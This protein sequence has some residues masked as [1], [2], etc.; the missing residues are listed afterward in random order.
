MSQNRL[1]IKVGLFVCICLGVLAGLLLEFSK[2][3]T[4]FRDTYS[5]TLYA[6]NVGGLKPRSQVLMS[7]V[8]VGTV[9]RTELDQSGTNVAIYL[10]IYS[11]YPI[12]SDA[13]FIIEQFGF[14]GDQYVA[15][16]PQSGSAEK[17]TS[18]AVVQ[19]DA[20]FNLQEVARSTS[21]FI[22]RLD[23]SARKVDAAIDEVRRVLLN[24]K[25]LSNLTDT[26]VNA[27][28]ASANA[29]TAVDNLNNLIQANSG[30]AG[31]AI[32]NLVTFS[33]Q[34]ED[35]ST[36][37]QALLST[38]GPTITAAI[39]NIQTSTAQITNLLTD[40]NSG[41]GLAGALLKDQALSS[42]VSAAMSNIAITTS[43]LNRMGFW[44]WLWYKPGEKSSSEG[45]VY[46]KSKP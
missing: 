1:E 43:N 31:T 9:A 12:R 37:A 6:P 40:L 27:R 29:V 18:G 15:I 17:L 13:R 46:P 24:D 35:F 39:S 3:V 20:P 32:T 23:V 8:Q 5:I 45:P 4:L 28:Q 25:A 10:K 7:G 38:N 42:N 14:L 19:C 16:Y 26:L 21:G 11:K 41:K 33:S 2:G 22:Q 30:P 36:H 44:H 34:L